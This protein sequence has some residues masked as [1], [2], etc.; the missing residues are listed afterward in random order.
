MGAGIIFYDVHFVNMFYMLVPKASIVWGL[1][2][3]KNSAKI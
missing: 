3:E 2:L 1:F